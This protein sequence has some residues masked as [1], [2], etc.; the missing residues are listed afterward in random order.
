MARASLEPCS[1][2][3]GVDALPTTLTLKN[4]PDAV[5]RRL[6]AAAQTHRRSMDSEAIV[7]LETVPMPTR[8]APSE[9]LARARQR[10]AASTRRTFLPSGID[11]AKPQGRPRSLSTPACWRPCPSQVNT[12]RRPKHCVYV[13]LTGRLPFFGEVNSGTSWLAT[14]VAKTLL[15]MRTSVY[16][17]KPKACSLP[18][19]SRPNPDMCLSL[20]AKATDLPMTAN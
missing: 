7:C 14:C 6:K 10:R 12:P 11:L 2:S 19:S 18:V 8:L 15:Q 16:N 13:T 4:I 17:W 1:L 9:R 20:S 3:A 5:Y